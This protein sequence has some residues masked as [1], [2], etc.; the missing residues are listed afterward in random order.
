MPVELIGWVNHQIDSELL[1]KQGP[2]FDKQAIEAAATVHEAS[3]FDT[4]LVGYFAGAPDG[5]LV[6]AHAATVTERLRFLIAH[7]PGFIAPTLAAR[8]FATF[9]HFTGGRVAVHMIAGGNDAEQATD[10]DF[11][12][13]D[14]RYARMAEYMAVMEQSWTSD[15]PFDFDGVHYC[16]VGGFS[17]IRCVQQPRMPFFGGG[18]S[19]AALETLAPC[20]DVFML[21]GEPLADTATIIERIRAAGGERTTPLTFSV[22]VR[23][24]IADREDQAWDKAHAVLDGVVAAKAR[25][26]DNQ[27]EN[28]G[29]QRLLE[30][31]ARQD[32]YDS[33]LWMPLATAT[34]AHGNTTALVG[35]PETVAKA[36]LAYYKLGASRI[37]IRG[38]DPLPD[39]EAYGHELIPRFRELVAEHDSE[40]D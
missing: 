4:A 14:S 18:G 36:L 35:T 39:A 16:V 6:A 27:P 13:K 33:C 12:D 20:L 9:D 37:L 15:T 40:A 2:V 1:G 17:D 3:G 7:R 34:G 11:L 29:S 28:R 26:Y 30:A 31:A 23:P 21:W 8:K 25:D 10:G 32:V 22:S 5:F 38:W 19:T 24:I